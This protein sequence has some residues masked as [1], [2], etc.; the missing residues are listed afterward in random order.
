MVD[1]PRN[2]INQRCVWTYFSEENR[3]LKSIKLFYKLFLFLN[4]LGVMLELYK[5]RPKILLRLT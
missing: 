4:C 3:Y 1:M 5:N 2:S